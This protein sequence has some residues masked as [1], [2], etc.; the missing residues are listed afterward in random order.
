MT[1]A[2]VSEKIVQFSKPTMKAVTLPPPTLSGIER[3]TNPLGVW[4]QTVTD[5]DSDPK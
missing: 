3:L 1:V 4:V 5:P 2:F